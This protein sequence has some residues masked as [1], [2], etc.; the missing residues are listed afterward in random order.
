M[1]SEEYFF[2]CVWLRPNK[3][4]RAIWPWVAHL[5]IIGTKLF[6]NLSTGLAEVV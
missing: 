3:N 4:K 6:Q 5:S 1:I 2:F